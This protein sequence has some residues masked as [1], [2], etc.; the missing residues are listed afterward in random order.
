MKFMTVS[1]LANLAEDEQAKILALY[2][3]HGAPAGTE[4]LWV[5]AD[6]HHVVSLIDVDDLTQFSE[7]NH[8]YSPE[9]VPGSV[10]WYPL[11]DAEVAVPQQL[12][13]IEA[14]RGQ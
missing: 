13:G 5:T 2:A 10:T 12:A 1:T 6:G 8:I 7:L 14:R 11:V 3:E 9:N 4:G